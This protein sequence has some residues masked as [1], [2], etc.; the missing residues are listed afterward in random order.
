MELTVRE[1]LILKNLRHLDHGLTVA[2]LQKILKVSRRTVY[3]ELASLQASLAR[4]EIQLIKPKDQGYQL[5]FK[6]PAQMTMVDRWIDQSQGLWIDIQER[7][8]A[9]ALTVLLSQGVQTI[10]ALADEFQV[11]YGTASKD[12]ETIS[13]ALASYNL[14]IFR[15][16]A[17]GLLAPD[18]EKVLR[19]VAGSL[20]YN[21]VSESEF[22]NHLENLSE[23]KGR[24]INHY[25][26][27]MIE[28]ASWLIAKETLAQEAIQ[29]FDLVNDNQ[30]QYILV[31][32]ALSID[33]IKNDHQLND[34]VSIK[35]ID[36]DLIK[37]SH[38][39]YGSIS[40]Q[41]G[42]SIALN[43]RHFFARLLAGV[44]YRK[45]INLFNQNFDSQLTF[46]VKEFIQQVAKQS[47]I[48]FPADSRLFQDLLAH[49]QASLN[50]PS[51]LLQKIDNSV[52][53]K[54]VE[55]YPEIFSAI[56]NHFDQIFF[57]EPGKDRHSFS[58]EELVYILLH[59][60]ASI[61]RMAEHRLEH[62]I[63]VV[64]SSGIGSSQILERRIERM[65]PQVGQIQI[66]KISQ[67]SQFN[68]EAYDLIVSTI[69]LPDF[70]RKYMLVSPLLLDEE[71]KNIKNTLAEIES[72]SAKPLKAKIFKQ[73]SLLFDQVYT[74]LTMAND[75]TTSFELRKIEQKAN[76]QASL[77]FILQSLDN[78]IIQDPQM[79]AQSLLE[80]YQLAPIGIPG[81][82]LA[83][84]H[85]LSH[86]V[87]QA[88]FGIYELDQPFTITGMD[89][90]ALTLKR[91]LILIGPDSISELGQKLLGHISQS[92]IETDQYLR[93][94][95]QGSEA[96]I[97][98]M[99][100]Q[101]FLERIKE[102]E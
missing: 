56:E 6:N 11:S 44:N 65:I 78:N 84:F 64:C 38:Q 60:A 20:I 17:V 70:P 91:M 37:L 24:S 76:L 66:A 63:L 47:E 92:I 26:L 67:L 46:Q 90:Q 42:Q 54:V 18:K 83:L 3:R 19:Q 23:N 28:P 43:E 73:N 79:V 51:G 32:L 101:V 52:L 15:Q 74:Y 85:C 93:T 89:G 7:Q 5:I 99:M 86:Q 53:L 55:Q 72:S 2:D 94:Y 30:L 95:N 31:M 16:P 77:L 71:I 27:Q 62:T 82:E 22:F 96:E 59:F 98:A 29:R 81:S 58:K 25:I 88:Y 1:Q 21:G 34:Q 100:K 8:Q 12:L 36:K 10:E 69:Q 9:M 57:R 61:D 39:I 4:E 49:I 13:N 35:G 14:E 41:I 33:R 97:K 102:F 48:D 45:D 68:L 50:R 75:L 40:L 87:N 80:R